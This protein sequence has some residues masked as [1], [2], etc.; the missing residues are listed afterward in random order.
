[1]GLGIILSNENISIFNQSSLIGLY[2]YR[3]H[4]SSKN[5]LAMGLQAGL[6]NY[7]VRYSQLTSKTANDPSLPGSDYN[8]WTP[9]FG[10]GIYFYNQKFYAGVSVPYLSSNIIRTRFVAYQLEQR[11]NYFLTTGYVFKLSSDLKI[12][13]S[14]LLRYISGNPIQADLNANLLFREVLWTGISYR[15]SKSFVLLLQANVTDQLRIGYSY[16][17]SIGKTPSINRGSH[18]IMI[19]YLFSFTKTNVDNPRYF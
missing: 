10:T 1:M 3:I 6:N 11:N 19:N 8:N 2:S 17:T 5:I 9:N 15:T 13:P 7:S 14:L 16:D 12:K 4:L 18:E